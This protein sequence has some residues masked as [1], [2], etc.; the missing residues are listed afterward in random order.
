MADNI[1]GRGLNPQTGTGDTAW[2]SKIATAFPAFGSKNYTLYFWG[3]L[4]S[5]I[6]T[7]LQ[8]VAQ[9]WLVLK[10]TNSAFLIGLVAAMGTFPTLLFTLFGGVIVDRF[11]KKKI[12]VLTQA[13]SMILAFLLGTL[14]LLNTIT[15]WQIALLAFCL[16]IVTALDAPARQ[17][18]VPEIVSSSQ[19]PSAIAINSGVFNGARVIGPGIAGLIIGLVGVGGAFIFN[20]LTY[21]AVIIALLNMKIE[22]KD[23]AKAKTKTFQAIKEGIT[24]TAKHPVISVLILMAGVLSIFGWSYTTVLPLIAKNKFHIGATGLGYLYSAS[25][26]GSLLAALIAGAFSSRVSPLWFIFG[27]NLLFVISIFGFTLTDNLTLSLV[28]LFFAGIG[29]LSMAALMNT[30]IQRQVS[31]DFRG[32]IMSIYVLMFL[33]MTPLGNLQIGFIAEKI[34]IDF[35]IR[36]GAVIVFLFGLVVF[37]YRNKIRQSYEKYKKE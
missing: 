33:G 26:L 17:S 25:G 8:I 19:L 14:T 22:K 31:D 15:V 13:L 37:F 28:L 2:V 5:L 35:A 24:Y 21:I 23:I 1:N 9:S 34:S 4:V 32:R 36:L 11:D 27:G 6:G 29:L 7:W 20:G 10:L 16:G 18:F 12:L 3:Q 30:T